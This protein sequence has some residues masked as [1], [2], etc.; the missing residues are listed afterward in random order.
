[1][2]RIK[3]FFILKVVQPIDAPAERSL[4]KNHTNFLIV[5]GDEK[6]FRRNFEVKIHATAPVYYMLVQGGLDALE[7][8]LYAIQMKISILI[9]LVKL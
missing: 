6:E 8:V 2:K 1:M 7:D 9:I 3:F 5:D 4:N